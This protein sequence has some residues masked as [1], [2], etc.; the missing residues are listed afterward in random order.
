[1]QFLDISPAKEETASMPH[2]TYPTHLTLS[3]DERARI[4]ISPS[5]STSSESPAALG[6][7]SRLLKHFSGS[8]S[9]P[10]NSEGTFSYERLAPACH[11]FDY[12]YSEGERM[13]RQYLYEPLTNDPRSIERKA[14]ELAEK[15]YRSAI[16]QERKD[17]FCRASESAG[18]KRKRIGFQFRADR[19]R[20]IA[21]KYALCIKVG[22]RLIPVSAL[23]NDIYVAQE[24]WKEQRHLVIG[25]ANR[26]DRIWEE[27]KYNPAHADGHPRKTIHSV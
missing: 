17:Y 4:G 7:R 18:R 20:E 23:F 9:F 25:C 12:R 21:G 6:H 15:A 22:K 3:D 2:A 11:R 13:P 5:A 27:P 14:Q 1:M 8:V 24:A 16:E 19:A 26:L 10:D